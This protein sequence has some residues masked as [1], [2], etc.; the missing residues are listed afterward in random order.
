MEQGYT[1]AEQA[2]SRPLCKAAL[3][4]EDDLGRN[5]NYLVHE[6]GRLKQIKNTNCK[7]YVL[8]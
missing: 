2:L 1:A 3:D 8:S 5:V 6:N 4:A 7:H